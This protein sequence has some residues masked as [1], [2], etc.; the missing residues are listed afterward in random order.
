[1]HFRAMDFYI[2]LVILFEARAGLNTRLGGY[3]R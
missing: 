1:M 3:N 2:R